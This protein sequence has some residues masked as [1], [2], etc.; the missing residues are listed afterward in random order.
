MIQEFIAF[1]YLNVQDTINILLKDYIVFSPV[2][3]ISPAIDLFY[4]CCNI[5]S[6]VTNIVIILNSALDIIYNVPYIGSMNT[7]STNKLKC[8]NLK[9]QPGTPVGASELL[10]MDI[11]RD[12]MVYYVKSG[13]LKRL[14]N[15]V[16]IK[17]N[18]TPS[19]EPCLKYLEHSM[20]GLHVGG[21]SALDRYGMR[22]YVS[23]KP[24]TYLYAW[25]SYKLPEW[26]DSSF[27]CK[28]QRKRLFDEQPE[29]PLYVSVQENKKDGPL[30]SEPE[31]AVLEMLSEIPNDQTLKEAEEILETAYNLRPDVMADL[32]TKCKSVKTVRLF[33][34][35]S[36]KLSLPVYESLKNKDLPTGSNSPWVYKT[37]GETMV[38][39]P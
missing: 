16:F 10:A 34:N 23:Y 30:V 8:L 25:E 38:L 29:N 6:Y 7:N 27:E 21:K 9:L 4:Y 12:L 32:L 15:G 1:K 19:F 13:W 14:A 5:R 2:N 20:H 24:R 33:L 36:K 39:K 11:S 3:Y 22:H 18:S 37:K 35:L 28:L 17:P 26:F 31:R